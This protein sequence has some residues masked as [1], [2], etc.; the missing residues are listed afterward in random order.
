MN[1]KEKIQESLKK[2]ARNKK[3]KELMVLRLLSAS[4]LNK[5]KEKRYNISKEKPELKEQDLLIQS[6]LSDDEVIKIIQ[7][8]IKKRKE[9][10]SWFE[11]GERTE[12]AEKEKEEQKFLEKYLPEQLLDEDIK[13]LAKESVGKTGVSEIKDIGKVMAEL[14]PKIKGRAGGS[15]VSDIVKQILISKKQEQ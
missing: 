15:R 11:K 3:E 10:I 12:M 9:A 5:E 2:S 14:M 6:Q 4:I 13:K 7:S 1:L 8:E